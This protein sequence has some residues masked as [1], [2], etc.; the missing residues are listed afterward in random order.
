MTIAIRRASNR[1]IG[2]LSALNADVQAIHAE[3]LPWLFKP[4]EPTMFARACIADLLDRP[5]KLVLI[6]EA[7]GTGAGYAYA[8]IIRR[9]ETAFHYANDMVYLHHIGVRPDFRRTGVGTA[10]IGAVRGAAKDNDIA[11]VALD[12]WAFNAAARAFFQR[13]GF[14]TASERMWSR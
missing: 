11:T 4:A 12:M 13:H 1:D 2:I 5:E 10:L 7:D 6:A 8:E 9:D 14:V 3:A